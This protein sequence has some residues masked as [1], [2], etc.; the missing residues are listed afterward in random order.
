MALRAG[1]PGNF[2]PRVKTYSA[3][4]GFVY[5]YRFASHTA[6]DA[7][8]HYRFG[9]TEDRRA[10]LDI[11]VLI[12]SDAVQ[13]WE[14][15]ECRILTPTERYAVA[16]LALFAALDEAEHPDRI[17]KPVVVNAVQVRDILTALDI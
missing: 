4:S 7:G 2:T 10:I 11:I 1:H 13:A 14:V 16:K 6:D 5:E 3:Q 8:D 9:A 12:R 15:D 17:P